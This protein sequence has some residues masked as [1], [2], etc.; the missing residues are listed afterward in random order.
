MK[1]LTAKF[2]PDIFIEVLEAEIRSVITDENTEFIRQY[3]GIIPDVMRRSYSRVR[4]LSPTQLMRLYGELA[5]ELALS[6]EEHSK[7]KDPEIT[8]ICINLRLQRRLDH[9]FSQSAHEQTR[10]TASA[11]PKFRK[12]RARVAQAVA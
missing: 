10:L 4:R 11:K 2:G 7:S 8:A 1:Q 5:F 9:V 12:P 6:E 3:C